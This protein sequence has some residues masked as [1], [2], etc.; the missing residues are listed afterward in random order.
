DR[1]RRSITGTKEGARKQETGTAHASKSS[2]A[3]AGMTM[4]RVQ[5]LFPVSCLLFPSVSS[6]HATLLHNRGGAI[7]ARHGAR[8]SRSGG[9][10]RCARTE[11]RRGR[12]LG[13]GERADADVRECAL[14]IV[15]YAVGVR[16]LPHA[17]ELSRLPG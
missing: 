12:N 6:P 16:W 9:G 11:S 7:G 1:T 15:A 5:F 8:G 14:H 3:Y 13:H 17:G 4:E 2:P 10:V